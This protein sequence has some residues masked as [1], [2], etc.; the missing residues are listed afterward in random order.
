[1]PDFPEILHFLV[2]RQ[3]LAPAQ[4]TSAMVGLLDGH[5]QDFETAAF[6]VALRMKGADASELAAAARALRERMLRLDTGGLE[7]LDTCGTGGDE[8]GTFNISTATAFVVAGAGVPVVKHGN[9]ASSGTVGSA[10]LLESLG[11]RYTG[12]AE[13]AESCLRSAGMAFCFAPDFHPALRRIAALR[14]R[15]RMRSLFNMVGPLA[16]P[17]LAPYQLIGVGR[18]EWLDPI[19]AAAAELGLR[20]GFV[21]CGEDGLDEVSLSARTLVRRVSSGRVTAEEWRPADFGLAPCALADLKAASP[22]DSAAIVLGVLQ[23]KDGPPTRVVLANAAA[24][25]LAAERASNLGDGVR[26]AK[27][28]IRTGRAQ[29]TLDRLISCSRS[30]NPGLC[31]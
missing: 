4:M 31:R 19:A 20:H 16:N 24:G 25:L 23:G 27:K 28:A 13:V 17:A 18:S 21:V 3:H 1:M 2:N 9:R 14:R 26:M 6:L 29:A 12:A 5:W 22:A 7:V 8:L 15:L 11:L 30:D 10:D